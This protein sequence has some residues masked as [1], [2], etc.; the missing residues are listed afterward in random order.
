[1]NP[2]FIEKKP[3]EWIFPSKDWNDCKIYYYGLIQGIKVVKFWLQS[4]RQLSEYDWWSGGD[5][6]PLIMTELHIENDADGQIYS[7]KF[8]ISN[9]YRHLYLGG[10]IFEQK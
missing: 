1:M 8:E 2:I 10:K 7:G 6:M 3:C 4:T 5:L 9:K